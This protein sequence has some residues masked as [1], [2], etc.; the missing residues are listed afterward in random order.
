MS[1]GAIAIPVLKRRWDAGFTLIE[2]L[3]AFVILGLIMVALAGGINFGTRAWEASARRSADMEEVVGV[4]S[5]LRRQISQAVITVDEESATGAETGFVGATDN[6]RF[7]APWLSPVGAGGIY[8]FDLSIEAAGSGGDLKLQWVLRHP[9]WSGTFDPQSRNQRILMKDISGL[10]IRYL[11][12]SQ[13][14]A[15]LTWA[16]NW[17]D[18]PFLP[19]LIEI[20]VDLPRG[21]GRVWPPLVIAPQALAL[22]Q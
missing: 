14:G 16:P 2:L 12:D 13:S 10:R 5:F 15:S 17:Q 9:E 11:G 4:Q 21:D 3:V 19:R 22:G 6:L 8:V 20:D 7:A 1:A 18:P